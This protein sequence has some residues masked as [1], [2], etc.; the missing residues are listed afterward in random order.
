M[1]ISRKK[2][3]F[4]PTVLLDNQLLEFVNSHKHFGL[5]IQTSGRWSLHIEATVIKINQ[6]LLV[7][8]YL[9]KS[10]PRQHLLILFNAFIKPYFELYSNVWLNATIQDV[11]PMNAAWIKAH[12]IV[13]G[14][15]SGTSHVR[16]LE[17]LGSTS[18]I[19]LRRYNS[20]KQIYQ[21]IH[22]GHPDALLDILID[23]APTT[24]RPRRVPTTLASVQSSSRSHH[25]SFLP[26]AIRE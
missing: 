26:S 15:K 6:R 23:S 5:V 20:V 7:L 11:I 16:L 10:L 14:G 8:K 12:Q 22:S 2:Q 4:L 9:S 13:S 18:L 17:E 25:E 1:V 19:N 21:T 24:V 3:S